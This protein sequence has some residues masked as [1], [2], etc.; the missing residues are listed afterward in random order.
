MS[1]NSQR[2]DDESI[3]SNDGDAVLDREVSRREAIG[4]GAA[5]ATAAMTVGV[6]AGSAAAA[7]EATIDFASERAHDPW[8]PGS[9][10]V[11]EHKSGMD[12]LGY[13]DDSGN[14]VSLRDDGFV[15]ASRQDPDTPHNPIEIA[16]ADIKADEFSAFPR[17]ETYDDDND[18]STDEVDVTALDATHWAVDESGTAGTMSVSDGD[19]DTLSVSTASQVAGDVATARFTD[20]EITSGISRKFL[21]GVVDV[22]TLES[23]VIVEISAEDSAGVQVTSE[24][25]PDG[26][27]STESV[28]SS[29]LGN[30]QVGESRVGELETAQGV[31]LD[32]IVAI[33]IAVIDAN[34]DL[35][36]HGFNAEK[37]SEWTFG[38]YEFLNSDS[39]VETEARTEPSGRFT[40]TSL[41][42]LP[43]EF[44]DSRIMSVGYD[45]EVRASELPGAKVWARSQ[46]SPDTY[47]RPKEIEIYVEF[48]GLTAYDLENMTFDS[49][50]DTTQ[51]PAGRYRDYEAATG[52]T[53]PDDWQDVDDISW[54]DRTGSISDSGQDVE[55]LSTISSTDLSGFHGRIVVS[56]EELSAMTMS[57]AGAAVAVEDEGGFNY[58]LT[59]LAGVFGG[60]GI[61][62]RK[63][64]LGLFGGLRG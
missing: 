61:L 32:D 10:T 59:V 53:E 63:H 39:E 58:A 5:A 11:V 48:E 23:G 51:F 27:T 42:T 64:I 46:D 41:S 37:E 6:G 36:F 50:M 2:S 25:R 18:T 24:I 8:I 45:F 21:Q 60:A 29:S 54:T 9:V 62:F 33:E 20:F 34:A 55:M 17:G 4:I 12:E 35:T 14:N 1:A 49:L 15:V 3:E 31:T 44:A 43:T 13:T 7:T 38:D 52:F 57:G 28:W 16:A 56:E 30:S 40:I 47:D 22:N 26:D 19:G